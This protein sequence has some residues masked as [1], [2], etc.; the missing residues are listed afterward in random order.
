MRHALRALYNISRSNCTCKTVLQSDVKITL[1]SQLPKTSKLSFTVWYII[2]Q[3]NPEEYAGNGPQCGASAQTVLDVLNECAPTLANP[4]GWVMSCCR[5]HR[6]TKS[7]HSKCVCPTKLGAGPINGMHKK[8]IKAKQQCRCARLPQS[9]SIP[10]AYHKW[11]SVAH[12]VHEHI[13][14]IPTLHPA[15]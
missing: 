15:H 12:Y 1:A 6:T 9:R 4:L 7:D 8:R 14:V 11:C 2:K 5:R 3:N 13:T 10:H